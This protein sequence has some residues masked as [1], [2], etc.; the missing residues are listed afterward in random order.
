MGDL[1]RFVLAQDEV[2]AQVRAEL[3]L[4]EKRSH[5]MWFV[6]PQLAGLGTS[7]LARTY[8]V[9]SL[10]EARSYLAHPVLGPRLAECTQLM[11]GWAGS[12]SAVAILG[13][14]DAIKFCSCM[15]LFELA[16]LD[17][18]NGAER[19]S[20]ALDNFCQGRRDERTL[21]LMPATSNPRARRAGNFFPRL[22]VV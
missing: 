9:R 1:D 18:G 5:W 4:G 17:N 7:P 13:T 8:A 15:T 11:L 2:Y 12:R 20:H 14:I 3:V 10:E 19:F 22:R 16:A 21:Q 6:F